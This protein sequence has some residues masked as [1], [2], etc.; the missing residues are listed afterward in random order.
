L[1]HRDAALPGGRILGIVRGLRHAL[2]VIALVVAL[3]SGILSLAREFLLFQYPT[4]FHEPPLFWA[5][6]RIAFG[7][8]LVGLWF[9]EHK[10]RSELEKS[11]KLGS[12]LKDRTIHLSRSILDFVYE[13]S[14]GVP[15]APEWTVQQFGNDPL[16]AWAETEKSKQRY[17][18][19]SAYERETLEIYEY[20]YAR[21]VTEAIVSLKNMGLDCSAIEESVMDLCGEFD[22][23]NPKIIIPSGMCIKQIGNQLGILADKIN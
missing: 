14:K 1:I 7:I 20:K 17:Q 4:K 22:P 6:L 19:I 13:R 21:D 5:C 23:D 8:S 3:M 15:S 2:S 18:G 12:S 10:K 16:S 11:L 9:D